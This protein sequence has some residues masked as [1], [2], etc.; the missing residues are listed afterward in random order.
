M[1]LPLYFRH[2]NAGLPNRGNWGPQCPLGGQKRGLFGVARTGDK[3]RRSHDGRGGGGYFSFL[4][5]ERDAVGQRELPSPISLETRRL[6]LWR[7]RIWA[8]FSR[9]M[10]PRNRRC[11]AMFWCS[12]WVDSLSRQSARRR[13]RL[14]CARRVRNSS[15]S[16]H[17]RRGALLRRTLCNSE[18]PGRGAR[19]FTLNRAAR[20]F[21]A[22]LVK[23]SERN[24]FRTGELGFGS[25]RER[26]A[27]LTR[28]E[29][30]SGS[31][32]RAQQSR[33]E[34]AVSQVKIPGERA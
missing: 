18:R 3:F 28:S 13:L 32:E 11:V 30:G 8:R 24:G 26:Y 15:P 19:A 7:Q 9:G 1:P 23:Q 17:A 25:P 14:P 2:G 10:A 27:P 5:V 16:A 12:P 33:L 21:R 29:W 31:I 6:M 4:P 34:R 20:S 22:R